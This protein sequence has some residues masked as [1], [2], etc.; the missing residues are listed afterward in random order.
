MQIEQA[1]IDKQQKDQLVQKTDAASSQLK[2]ISEANNVVAK[3]LSDSRRLISITP[4]SEPPTRRK[5]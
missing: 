4:I 3:T 2:T 5:R 1:Q